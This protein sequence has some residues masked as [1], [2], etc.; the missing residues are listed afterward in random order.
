MCCFD[1]DHV[2]LILPVPL[3]FAKS[4]TLEGVAQTVVHRVAR[5]HQDCFINS[6]NKRCQRR[7]DMTLLVRNFSYPLRS[8]GSST[9]TNTDT[10]AT[11]A[12]G[13]PSTQT[14]SSTA[15]SEPV[16][17]PYPLSL[18]ADQRVKPYV[19][20]DGYRDCLQQA[21]EKGEFTDD[22]WWKRLLNM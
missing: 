12:T 18:D 21:R 15:S 2:S 10:F 14:S 11:T 20:F 8:T 9:I 22:T 13:Q 19:S 4:T 17:N 1:Y 3:Q 16:T 5:Q 7:E 6:G